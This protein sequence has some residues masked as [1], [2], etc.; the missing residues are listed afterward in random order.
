MAFAWD[1][2]DAGGEPVGRSEAFPDRDA[3]E[4]WMGEAWEELLA[5]GVEEAALVDL[6]RDR[7]IYRMGLREA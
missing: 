4:A 7:R 1:Y 3:A 5:Q 2:L 6:E